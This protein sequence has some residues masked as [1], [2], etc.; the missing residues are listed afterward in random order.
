MITPQQSFIIWF[1]PR[2]GSSLLCKSL[3]DT[4][5]CGKA[6]EYLNDQ[7]NETLQ[8]FYQVDNFA[9][10]CQK[11][12]IKGSSENGVFGIKY[13]IYQSHH[14]RV[15]EELSALLGLKGAAQDWSIMSRL[16]PNC[17]HIFLTRRNKVRLAA[18]W[19]K[20]I[21]DNQWHRLSVD[22][23]K[24]DSSFYKDKYD[25]NALSHLFKE[26]C[27]REAMMEEFFAVNNIHPLTV[28]Y[29]D[30][31]RDYEGTLIS[32]LTHL[33]IKHSD[34]QLQ[35]PFYKKTAD[36]HTEHWIQKFRDDLQEGWENRAW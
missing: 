6:G 10:L 20:A 1:A 13:S 15:M 29:E 34:I 8:V 25:V 19:W 23:G 26:A 33:K 36:K 18:S 17:R 21:Q 30:F 27:L 5:V 4:G 14:A 28:V 16:F 31:I 35:P 32:I 12:W 22:Q 2:T 11:L 9:D 7:Q 3:E 24:R